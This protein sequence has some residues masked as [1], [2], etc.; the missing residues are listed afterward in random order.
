VLAYQR[1]HGSEGLLVALNF[2]SET[3]RR[4]IKGAAAPSKQ[5][6][7]DRMKVATVTVDGPDLSVEL[8]PLAGAVIGPQPAGGR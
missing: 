4:R 8:P 7:V 1:S 6:L 5:A 3:Q 2:S